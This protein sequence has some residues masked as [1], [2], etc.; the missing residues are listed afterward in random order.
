MKTHFIH[1]VTLTY[2]PGFFRGCLWDTLPF[3]CWWEI[4]HTGAQNTFVNGHTCNSVYTSRKKENVTQW[5]ISISWDHKHKRFGH[6]SAFH[7]EWTNNTWT[8]CRIILLPFHHMKL[9]HTSTL[10]TQVVFRE[11]RNVHNIL[12]VHLSYTILR[13]SSEICPYEPPH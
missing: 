11:V 4:W 3:W 9:S 7:R 5:T 13:R 2:S 10:P 12:S 6:L 8:R 1:Y